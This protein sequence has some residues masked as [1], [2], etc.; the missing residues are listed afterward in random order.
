MTNIYQFEAELLDGKTKSM[1]DYR[2]KVLLIVNT[3]SKCG[4][5][6][7][8]AGL[9]KVYQKYK[10]QGLEVLGFPCN[11]FGG[12]DP[13]TNDQI[14]AFCQKNYGVSFPMFAKVDVKGPEAHAVFRYLTNNS[15]GI[16]GNGIKWNFTKFLVGKNGEVLNRY[17]PTSKPEALEEDIERAL[18]Q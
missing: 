7:Q 6:P 18:A 17:A 5:T 2:G 9:E 3:A 16:L 14:G 11:Q 4:F 13:G 8:F 1:A 10:D 12:Q 15:K